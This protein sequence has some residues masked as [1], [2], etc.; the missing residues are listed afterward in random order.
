MEGKRKEDRNAS[1]PDR[2]GIPT[3]CL[4]QWSLLSVYLDS[5]IETDDIK[6]DC[7]YFILTVASCTPIPFLFGSKNTLN[8]ASICGKLNEI[9]VFQRVVIVYITYFS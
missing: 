5:I 6:T 3:T 1:D 4:A 7:F 9:I 8:A 2:L